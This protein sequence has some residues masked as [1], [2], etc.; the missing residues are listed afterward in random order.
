[1]Y[2]PMTSSFSIRIIRIN[3]ISIL[4]PLPSLVTHFT[5]H[6]NLDKSSI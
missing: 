5:L 6:E 2:T 3:A 1:M 4:I